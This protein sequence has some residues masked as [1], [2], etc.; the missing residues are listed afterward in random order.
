M[1]SYKGSKGTIFRFDSVFSG[2]IVI[3]PSNSEQYIEIPAED[4]LELVAYNYVLVAKMIKL[5]RKNYRE[6]LTG[7]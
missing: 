3:T 1:H 7:K 2:C 6:L 5:E 4:I